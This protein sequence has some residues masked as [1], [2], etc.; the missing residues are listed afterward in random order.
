M[1]T[2]YYL[3]PKVSSEI[4]TKI[5]EL[6]DLDKF[7]DIKD[8]LDNYQDIHIGK[9]SAG[10]KFLWDVHYFDY[11]EPS[12]EAIIEWLKSGIIYDEYG[13]QYTLEEFFKDIK[14]DGEFNGRKLLDA[15]EYHKID[16]RAY[17][18]RNYD[19]YHTTRFISKGIYPNDLGE[20]Y[21]DD[22]RCVIDEDFS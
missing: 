14:L 1:G 4:K 6:V 15:E 21:L 2:N 17:A 5:K 10:W 22:F 8:I 16:P 18:F 3:R 20:F 13:D 19:I 7:E 12:K 9:Q 11:Y